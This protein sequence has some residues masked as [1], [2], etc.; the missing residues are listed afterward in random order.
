VQNIKYSHPI[1]RDFQRI[2]DQKKLNICVFLVKVCINVSFR[3]VI[4]YR[5]GHW[6]YK[7]RHPTLA[8]ITENLNFYLDQCTISV[9]ADIG[10]G[11]LIAHTH[12]LV[13][14]EGC[15]IGENCDVRQNVTIGGNWSKQ[16]DGRMYPTIGDNVSISAGAVI[17]GPLNIGSN[18]II[19]A[20]TVVTKDVPESS[21]VSGIPAKIIGQKW[22][23]ESNRKL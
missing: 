21:I 13:I 19:G 3:A 10:P 18:S 23:E 20:N 15:V 5:V 22:S 12:G 2:Y 8:K 14:G 1:G 7:N 4:L 6:L 16:V 9:K 17:V 11:F